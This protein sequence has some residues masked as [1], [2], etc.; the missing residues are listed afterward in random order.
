MV[1]MQ[2]YMNVADNSG[3]RLVQ[4]IKVLGGSH[5]YVDGVGVIVVVAVKSALPN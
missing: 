3:A 2:S 5:R 4:V 1:Q